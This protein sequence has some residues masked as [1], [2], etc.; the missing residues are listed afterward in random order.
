MK[1]IIVVTLGLSLSPM[2]KA[3][4]INCERMVQSGLESIVDYFEEIAGAAPIE[5]NELERLVRKSVAAFHFQA[6]APSMSLKEVDEL[7]EGV[8]VDQVRGK[9]G[10][11]Y[12]S[13]NVGFGGGNSATYYYLPGTLTFV[14][15][16]S[17]DGDC[18]E[19][20]SA[21]E[22]PVEKNPAVE[23]IGHLDCSLSEG[24]AFGKISVRVPLG[25]DGLLFSSSATATV[26]EPRTIVEGLQ[27]ETPRS[28]TV[29][30]SYYGKASSVG[31]TI[32]ARAKKGSTDWNVNVAARLKEG[33][34]D[35]FGRAYPLIVGG[36]HSDKARDYN[37]RGTCEGNLGIKNVEYQRVVNF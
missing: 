37:A 22:F 3:E 19:Q 15:V 25:H 32:E 34:A 2:A 23:T 18:V 12:V 11:R 21:E 13:V 27:I 36:Y 14:P 28:Q 33:R 10:E 16:M 35:M 1:R 9:N 5:E 17:Y 26:A 20:G 24:A 31:F 8:S 7:G 4:Q 6:Y 30:I 29:N